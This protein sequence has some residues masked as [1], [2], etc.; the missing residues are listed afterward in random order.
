MPRTLLSPF[1]AALVLV[2][3]CT[4]DLAAAETE[5]SGQS[6]AVLP[7]GPQS[8]PGAHVHDGFYMRV[9]SG[10]GVMDERLSA[11]GNKGRNRGM[12]TVGE[13]SFGGTLGSGWVLGGGI[14]SADLIAST[15]KSAPGSPNSVPLELDP[16]LRG[17]ALIAPFFDWYPNPARGFHFQA[18]LGLATLT[19]RVFGDPA[20][21]QS[22]Y[23]A[24]G[25]ALML[26]TGYE[27]WVADEWS[28]GIL[29]RTT[30]AVLGGKDEAAVRWVHIIT[31]SPSLLLS[32]TYH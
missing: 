4:S 30:V 25:G 7:E 26:G 29:T 24:V 32:L 27:W 3:L 10:F 13:L 28:L 19:P 17:L 12:A 2:A 5:R 11:S 18:A 21:E 1:G 15:Y 8:A 16:E 14:Y 6:G 20:T 9:A 22:E 31:T 23:L